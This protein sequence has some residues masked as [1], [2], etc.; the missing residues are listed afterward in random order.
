MRSVG[1]CSSPPPPPVAPARAR[2]SEREMLH[3]LLLSVFKP[4]SLAAE[5]EKPPG[6]FSRWPSWPTY[7]IYIYSCSLSRAHIYIYIDTLHIYFYG[8]EKV[9][10]DHRR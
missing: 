6:T 1:P 7:N 10:R 3:L 8:S 4:A 2:A 9:W 5:H